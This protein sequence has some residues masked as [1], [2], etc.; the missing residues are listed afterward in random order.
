MPEFE[1]VNL[2]REGGVARIELNRPDAL[3]A[4]NLQLGLDLREAL[5]AVATDD[6][7]RAVLLTGAGRA[8]SSGAD[9]AESREDTSDSTDESGQFDLS[10]RLRER[11][12]PIIHAIRDMPKPVVSAVNGPAAGIGCSLALSADLIVAAHSSFFLLAFVNIGLVPDGGSTA[13]VPAR[14]GLARATEM[15]MLGERVSAEKAL[16]WGLVNRVVANEELQSE[17]HALVERL[18]AGPTRSYAGAKALLNR[19]IYADLDGQLEAEADTQREMGQSKDFF[20]GVVAFA[21][22]R[23]PEFT[24]R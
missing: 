21:Q 3:N 22:K 13:F 18:A 4:W 23:E 19:R 20:E 8:F 24:G 5:E 6:E 16:E 10:K 12:H 2:E 14:I 15:M 1:T 11:Y 7:V 9:L 17:S